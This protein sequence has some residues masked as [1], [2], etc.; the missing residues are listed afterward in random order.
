MLQQKWVNHE[1]AL[2]P[3]LLQATPSGTEIPKFSLNGTEEEADVFVFREQEPHLDEG[4]KIWLQRGFGA[5]RSLTR[6]GTG[7]VAHSSSV[8]RKSLVDLR[9]GMVLET[10]PK[11]FRA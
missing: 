5:I 11:S 8:V 4:L 7:Y 10:K 6:R 2:G 3:V 9:I 1:E